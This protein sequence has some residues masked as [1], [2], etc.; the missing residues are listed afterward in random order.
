MFFMKN[1]LSILVQIICWNYINIYL[2]DSSYLKKQD[3]EVHLRSLKP[4][5][6]L[7]LLHK[8]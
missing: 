1:L 6:S 4:G 5:S 8:Y 7:I 2:D 3:I